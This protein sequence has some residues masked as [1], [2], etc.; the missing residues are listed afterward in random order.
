[1]RKLS[2]IAFALSLAGAVRPQSLHK[3]GTIDLPGPKGQ[4]FDYLTTD[5]EDRYVLSAH[6]GPGILYVIDARTDKLVKAIP[7]VPGIT[8]LE[9][10]PGLHKIYTSNWGENKIGV[11]DLKSMTVVKRLPT[12]AKP[13]GSVY[14]APFRKVYVSDTD[15]MAVAIVDVDRDAIV[16]TLHFN[17]ETGMPQYDSVAKKVYVNLRRIN[18]IAEIDPATDTVTARYPVAGCEHNH[19]MAVDSERHRAF[20]LCGGN[21]TFTVFA[22]DTH[23]AIAH[24]P[25]P[26]GAD[27]VKFDAG[28]GRIYAACS[29]GFISVFQER[30]A[31][32][33]E[34]VEDFPV[35]KLVHSLA[36]DPATHRVYAPEQEE[37]GKPVAKMVIYEPLERKPQRP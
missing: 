15:G 22:L 12:A 35:Q 33:F 28:T 23:K 24:F 17:S 34:K 1:M 25:L 9:Y 32:R 26:A 4:R 20:L 18:E 14:A 31:N 30:D 13:N 19:G 16:K 36:V 37:D 5:D 6:L 21:R 7:G 11:I 10:V 2:C 27:V 8:G 3:V 29:S